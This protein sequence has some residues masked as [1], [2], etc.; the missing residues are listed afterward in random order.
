M[1]FFSSFLNREEGFKSINSQDFENAINSS[2]NA[3]LLD[4]R[5]KEEHNNERIANS[6]LIDIYKPDFQKQID[7]LDRNKQYYVYCHSG[8]R[9]YSACQLMVK[10][11]FDQIY[12]L[13]N[14]IIGWRGEV[15]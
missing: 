11:G 4:V 5:T 10:M 12:N 7:K 2:N 15:V 6:I 13:Q 1:S 8:S 9:S 14:G 3:V